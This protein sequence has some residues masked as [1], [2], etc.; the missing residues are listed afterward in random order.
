LCH[1]KTGAKL[2]EIPADATENNLITLILLL[3]Y[4]GAGDGLADSNGN[5]GEDLCC[6]LCRSCN[7]WQQ[8]QPG[9]LLLLTAPKKDV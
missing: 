8:L 1:G 9:I 4:A 3:K 5:P 7:A 6:A 2:A